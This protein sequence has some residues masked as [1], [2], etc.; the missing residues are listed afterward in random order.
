MVVW[1]DDQVRGFTFGEPLSATQS[2]IVIEKT[3]LAIKGLAQFIFSE[4]CR[5]HWSDRPLVNV[6]DDWGVKNLAWTKMSYRPVQ[7]LPKF[8]LTRNPAVSVRPQPVAPTIRPAREA[9]VP[10]VVVSGVDELRPAALAAGASDVL[11]KPC[12]REQLLAALAGAVRAQSAA[13]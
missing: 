2:S 3:D 8:V 4:F 9:D 5:T 12:R 10:I 13:A 11:V 1:V 6:G 7:L